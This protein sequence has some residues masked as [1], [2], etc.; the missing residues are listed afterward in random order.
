MKKRQGWLAGCLAFTML[1]TGCRIGNK[2]IVITK[3]LSNRYVF[4]IGEVA[5][6]AEEVRLYLA[7]YQNIYGTAY[8]LDLWQHDFGDESLEEYIKTITLNELV[9]VVSM[10]QLA[11]ANKVV[12]SEEEKENI[13]QAA[14]IY[15][16]SLSE[17][18]RKY[19]D[20]TEAE[21]EGYYRQY[22]LAQK[23]YDSLT[24]EI[25]QEVSDDE[26]RVM[27]IMQIYVTEEEKA[28]EVEARL[29]AGEDFAGIANAYH[30]LE[31]IQC[32]ISR[33]D[34]PK[35]V[36]AVAFSMDNYEIS[37]KIAVEGGY[38]FLKCLNKY[39]EELTEENKGT[40]VEKREQAAFTG[41]YQEFILTLDSYL[42]EEVWD[43]FELDTTAEIQTDSFFRVYESCCGKNGGL[44]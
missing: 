4:K 17:A 28:A 22:A 44:E 42:N 21:L 20:V 14:E 40:I 27:E 12:L 19:L 1:L 13:S 38:Y 30:E 3:P 23:V 18:E 36:E 32:Y 2:N 7:N 9:S 35:E 43:S 34:V 25:N 33:D 10:A 26:A 41:V 11:E 16:E 8:T 39:Q 29:S 15:Y 6:E 37:G 24:G 31:E 5:C